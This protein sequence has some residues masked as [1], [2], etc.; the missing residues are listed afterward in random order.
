MKKLFILLAFILVLIG[1]KNAFSTE[2]ISQVS[3]ADV[4]KV[5]IF[6]LDVGDKGEDVDVDVEKKMNDFL[7][8]NYK[9]EQ[10]IQTSAGG[11]TNGYFHFHTIITIFYRQK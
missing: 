4:L 6:D 1:N 10:I 5:K 8:K 9:I 7:S 3:Q 2:K 11:G